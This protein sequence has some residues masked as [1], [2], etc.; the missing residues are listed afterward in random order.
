MPRTRSLAWSELKIGIASVVAMVLLGALVVA[1]GGGGGFFWQR[2]P[3]RTKFSDVQG[4]KAGGVV[5]LSGKEIGTI[6]AVEFSGTDV[7]V[8]FEVVESVRPLLTTESVAA[9][10]SISLLGETIVE[11]KAAR[12][13]TPLGDND[14]MKSAPV[15]GS[16]ADLADSAQASMVQIDQLVADVR[17][18]RGTLGKIVTDDALY[19]DMTALLTTAT[20]VTKNLEAG[21]GTLGALM[22]DREAYNAL[23]SSLDNLQTMTAR[24][25]AGQGALG[26]LLN[27][28]AT[29]RALSSA[30]GN[31][32]QVTGR[33]ARGEGTVG[34]LLTDAE[35]FDRLNAMAARFDEV[36]AGLSAGR[37]TAGLLLRDQQLYENMNRAV[38]ELQALVSDIRRDPKKYLRVN[39]SIF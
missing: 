30:T 31:L 19:T 5:R 29:G 28:D 13:G 1:V 24:I 37:G 23:K 4:L 18:G 11:I 38:T 32:D 14:Y 39:V 16:F 20:A 12:G 10:G 36:A 34:K 3:L 22:N 25:N 35:L 2:Y 15:P 21:R 26:R 17:A 27:D 7:E 8:Q 6:T 33:L 9:I